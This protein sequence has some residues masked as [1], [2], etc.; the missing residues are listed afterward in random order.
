MSVPALAPV[1]CGACKAL[2]LDDDGQPRTDSRHNCRS[3]ACPNGRRLHASLICDAVWEPIEGVLF[4]GRACLDAHNIQL[5]MNNVERLA[6][7]PRSG[8]IVPR[9]KPGGC[10][11]EP[12]YVTAERDRHEARDRMFRTEAPAYQQP[13][14][15]QRADE[16]MTASIA[17]H[18]QVTAAVMLSSVAFNANA[19]TQPGCQDASAPTAAPSVQ[20]QQASVAHDSAPLPASRI[21]SSTSVGAPSSASASRSTAVP[22]RPL[23]QW[24]S[25]ISTSPAAP[26]PAPAA[27][28][29]SVASP[30]PPACHT[31]AAAPAATPTSASTSASKRVKESAW[32]AKLAESR[33]SGEPF[34]HTVSVL[35]VHA[36][37]DEHG[38]VHSHI[39]CTRACIVHA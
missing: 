4:C 21:A 19:R 35:H 32:K 10:P 36:L 34:E 9:K 38:H 28:P 24:S 15:A 26:A 12:C 30:T 11:D 27:A 5:G 18:A 8:I 29:A 20:G 1:R 6:D 37:P 16:R 22:S 25:V 2:I 13:P 7:E 33:S 14:T 17:S 39:A 3:A 23:F 31:P